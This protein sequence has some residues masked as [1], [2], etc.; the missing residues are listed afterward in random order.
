[1]NTE[2]DLRNL[3]LNCW[4]GI[5]VVANVEEDPKEI[6]IAALYEDHGDEFLFI[7]TKD[8]QQFEYGFWCNRKYAYSYEDLIRNGAPSWA[9]YVRLPDMFCDHV[10]DRE[11][12]SLSN[13]LYSETERYFKE[14]RMS[15]GYNKKYYSAEVAQLAFE[16]V[17]NAFE[18]A[19][20]RNVRYDYSDKR[21]NIEGFLQDNNIATPANLYILDNAHLSS[22]RDGIDGVAAKRACDCESLCGDILRFIIVDGDEIDIHS[23]LWDRDDDYDEWGESSKIMR[24]DQF[25]SDVETKYKKEILEYVSNLQKALT[26]ISGNVNS[27]SK[28]ELYTCR[29]WFVNRKYDFRYLN[30]FH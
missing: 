6:H 17:I 8:G 5:V 3:K 21:K 9:N 28:T 27:F 1:M 12:S 13:D 15:S 30:E 23:V 24:L 18:K 19:Y 26:D 7:E 16:Q 20:S 14:N 25:E 11:V 29:E 4:D 2:R 22:K 10:G